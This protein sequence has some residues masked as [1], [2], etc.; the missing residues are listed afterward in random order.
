MWFKKKEKYVLTLSP[1]EARLLR[2]SMIWFRNQ[3]IHTGKPT[4]DIDR[5]L[6]KIM[7]PK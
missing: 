6:L 1:A 2:N 3:V 5:I 4:E 7:Q